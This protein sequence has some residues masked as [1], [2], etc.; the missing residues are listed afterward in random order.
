MLKIIKLFYQNI[1]ALKPLKDKRKE[2]RR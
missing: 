1:E 2:N